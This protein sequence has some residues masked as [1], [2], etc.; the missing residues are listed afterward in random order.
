M[1]RGMSIAVFG[2]AMIGSLGGGLA[3]LYSPGSPGA[4][5]H[6]PPPAA[7]AVAP[8]P[9]PGPSATAATVARAERSALP[10]SSGTL[11][12]DPS[13]L[14]ATQMRAVL[15]RFAAWSRDHAGAPCPDAAALGVVALDPWGHTL[16]LTCADQPA[17]QMIG[18][19][20]AGSDGIVGN[21]DDVASWALGREVTDLVRGARWKSTPVA[22][23]A[24]PAT[25]TPTLKRS[26]ELP[27]AHGHAPTTRTT[28]SPP[29][30]A[31]SGPPKPGALPID[32][33]V[34]D[35]PARR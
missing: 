24:P 32:A 22:A 3:A 28:P 18:A 1:G 29:A 27:S 26:R 21:R 9:A 31:S 34:D 7:P 2:A 14:L 35:I 33:G 30:T 10:A 17:D 20:S 23:S 8:P 25:G 19:I 6:P 5:P 11:P 13:A 15:T 12:P 4:S 16:V